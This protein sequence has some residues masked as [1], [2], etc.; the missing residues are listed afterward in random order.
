VAIEVIMPKLGMTMEEGTI[1]AWLKQEGEQ[2]SEGEPL[3]E[4]ETDKVTMEVPAPASG[5]LRKVL[6]KPG[7]T[8]SVGQTIAF[9]AQP[10]EAIDQLPTSQATSSE[11]SLKA[12]EIEA[13]RSEARGSEA[14]TASDTSLRAS[15]AAKKLAREH[16][17]DLRSLTG[18]GP[19]GRILESDVMQAI[20]G[21][22]SSASLPSS[23]VGGTR[24]DEVR[25]TPFAKGET[26][27]LSVIRKRTAE[28]MAESF[29]TI[30][31]FYLT[32]EVL[33]DR[34]AVLREALLGPVQDQAGVRLSYTDLLVKGLAL[35][36]RQHPEVNAAW[37]HG[38]IRRSQDVNVGIA[39]ATPDGLVVPVIQRAD[40]LSV[41]EIAQR[42][43]AVIE[44]ARCKKL[45]F[46][47]VEGGTITLTNLG[48]YGVDT[49]APIINPPQAAILAA[50]RITERAVAVGGLLALRPTLFLTLAA[51]H[52][53]L[54]GHE[55]ATFLG[56]LRNWIENVAADRLDSPKTSAQNS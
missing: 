6:A 53:I 24:T 31:H 40:T 32:M 14:E 1:V 38:E 13:S 28:R 17:V 43:V 49:F 37:E 54:D 33:A 23:S 45:S 56:D 16:G 4:V 48:A 19:S 55:A 21:L 15:P 36:L 20:G 35:V 22:S 52:R 10:G 29:Q 34:L 46:D 44:A 3:F 11:I 51:D 30:P 12:I 8:M 39:V 25:R 18:S 42:R 41:A 5:V 47:S 26:V 9:I 2:L 27:K 50:G 7:S